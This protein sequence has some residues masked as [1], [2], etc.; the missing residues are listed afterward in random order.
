MSD[1]NL[2]KAE[3]I[4]EKA[5]KQLGFLFEGTDDTYSGRSMYDTQTFAAIV[6]NV[7]DAD[8][9]AYLASKDCPYSFKVDNY[10]KQYVVYCPHLA[11]ELN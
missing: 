4:L 7:R 2:I 5:R 11:T 6:S 10:G 1:Q 8:A 3:A 9:L